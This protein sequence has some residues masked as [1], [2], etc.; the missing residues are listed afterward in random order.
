MGQQQSSTTSV[1][2]PLGKNYLISY[3]KFESLNI[4]NE[5]MELDSVDLS[6]Y[7]QPGNNLIESAFKY[8]YSLVGMK[9]IKRVYPENIPLNELI[10]LYLTPDTKVVCY[11]P[12]L[13]NIKRLL[14][15]FNVLIAGIIIDKELAER[16]GKKVNGI[17]TDIVLIV[18]YTPD[19]LIL[20]TTWIQDLFYL[21]YSFSG[22]IKEIHQIIK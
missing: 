11:N 8:T 20:K 12:S 17:V 7:L 22:N 15:D 4:E 13:K 6:N 18:G 10:N 19:S 2:L 9:Y 5:S 1:Q 14:S 3:V 16:F 21:N